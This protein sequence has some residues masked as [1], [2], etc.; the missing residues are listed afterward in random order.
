MKKGI[1][2]EPTGGKLPQ[3]QTKSKKQL[4]S[5]QSVKSKG[6]IQKTKTTSTTSKGGG[7][8]AGGGGGKFG[9]SLFGRHSPWSLLRNDKNF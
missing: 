6:Y 2:S 1:L 5:N 8:S 3:F 9:R 4:L 7:K